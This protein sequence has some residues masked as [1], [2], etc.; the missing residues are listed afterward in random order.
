M[1]VISRPQ[2]SNN[3]HND[4]TF[5]LQTRCLVFLPLAGGTALTPAQ[6]LGDEKQENVLNC[7]QEF[8]LNIA[9]S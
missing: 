7:F 8:I 4:L 3:L 9:D 5:P 6:Q 1:A 2:K